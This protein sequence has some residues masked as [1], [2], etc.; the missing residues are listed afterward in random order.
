MH[1][2]HCL[3]QNSSLLRIV[4]TNTRALSNCTR[5]SVEDGSNRKTWWLMVGRVKYPLLEGGA[6]AQESV[7]GGFVTEQEPKPAETHVRAVTMQVIE[8]LSAT[9]KELRD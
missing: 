1:S 9:W 2:V 7:P 6:A 5:H 4:A 3:M 8:P